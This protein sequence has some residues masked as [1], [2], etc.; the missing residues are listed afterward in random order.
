MPTNQLSQ[1]STKAKK[2]KLLLTGLILII[3]Y[4]IL[5]SLLALWRYYECKTN[6]GCGIMGILGGFSFLDIVP[7]IFL[8]TLASTI[9]LLVILYLYIK[10][11]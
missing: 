9:T 7:S 3:I 6:G 10:I 4:G 5:A 1:Q 11:K 8:F 2:R